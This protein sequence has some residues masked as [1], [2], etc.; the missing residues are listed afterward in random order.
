MGLVKYH[1]SVLVEIFRNYARDFR[2]QEVMIAVYDNI[3]VY[4][5]LS[6]HKVRAYTL[7]CTQFFQVLYVV[8]V[9]RQN[10]VSSQRIKFLVEFAH[11]YGLTIGMAGTH[12]RCGQ[13]MTASV[14]HA[15]VVFAGDRRVDA[16]VFAGR[17]NYAQYVCVALVRL[18]VVA[19]HAQLFGG[20][21]DLGQCSGA[22]QQLCEFR[23]VLDHVSDD[24]R[25]YGDGLTRARR[26][27]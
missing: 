2:V 9:W 14:Y 16:Q 26:H 11:I 19:Q 12:E 18:V 3:G 15:S 5:R 24:Q 6:G 8:D 17:Q 22:V 23:R 25:Q 20:L 21:F 1:Y 27:L 13:C 7:F 4:K 10:R